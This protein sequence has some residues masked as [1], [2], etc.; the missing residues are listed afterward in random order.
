MNYNY[1][2]I[3]V[4]KLFLGVLQFRLIEHVTYFNNFC[5][6]RKLFFSGTFKGK[7]QSSW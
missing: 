1:P 3:S 2:K 6:L 7:F 4:C 5:F